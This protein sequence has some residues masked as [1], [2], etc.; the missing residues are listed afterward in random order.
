MQD[1]TAV[2][3]QDNTLGLLCT[4]GERSSIGILT[5]FTGASQHTAPILNPDKQHYRAAKLED[6][7]TFRV[8][9]HN[10]Y[11]IHGM[12]EQL[13]CLLDFAASYRGDSEY[14]MLTD[15]QNL[16]DSEKQQDLNEFLLNCIDSKLRQKTIGFTPRMLFCNL[17]DH[18]ADDW[19]S[20]KLNALYDVVK[21]YKEKA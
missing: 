7:N 15:L 3:Y 9:Y 19:P 21:T 6:F 18:S 5:T 1:N 16:L 2:V 8:M 12:D 20:E 10:S 17:T 11:I 4:T 14:H 13:T